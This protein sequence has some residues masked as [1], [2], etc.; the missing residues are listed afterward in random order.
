VPTGIAM[1][2]S[3]TVYRRMLQPSEARGDHEPPDGTAPRVVESEAVP[4]PEASALK[5]AA[6]EEY[7]LTQHAAD[8]GY[9]HGRWARLSAMRLHQPTT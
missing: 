4:A 2:L 1:I 5:L 6:H 3:A 9:R 8:R 7:G